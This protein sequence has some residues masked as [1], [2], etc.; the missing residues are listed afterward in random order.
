MRPPHYTGE[1]GRAGAVARHGA[2]A[3]MR[4]PHYT[5]EDPTRCPRP[6]PS[7]RGFNEA[8]ALHGGRPVWLPEE[9]KEPMTASM[10]PP[11]YTGEDAVEAAIRRGGCAGF[12]EAPRIT[13]GKTTWFGNLDAGAASLQ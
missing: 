6:P 12:N 5:G 4:P 8:P 1:D 10:R 7:C 2:G 9:W 13:R 3:S 11:H